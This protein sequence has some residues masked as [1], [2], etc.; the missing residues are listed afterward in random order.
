VKHALAILAAIL[1]AAL[2]LPVTARAQPLAADTGRE[3]SSATRP[4]EVAVAAGVR[5]AIL[6][7]AGLDP[8]A[9][10]S[11][12][13][14]MSSVSAGVT[15]FRAGRASLVG[16]LE[17]NMGSRSDFARG[18]EASVTLHRLGLALETRYQPARRL[19]LSVKLAPAAFA[20]LGSIQAPGIDRPLVARPWT[21][22]LDAT[23]GAG[24]L[25]GT[26]GPSARPSARFWLTAELGYAFAGSA[27]MRYAPASDAADPSRYGSV[28]LPAFKP[29][30]GVGRLGLAVAF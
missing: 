17:W 28:M 13:L 9:P 29:A 14:V 19:Y 1:A 23:G 25:L 24:L 3:P 20:V 27:P 10:G 4:G 7:G 2:A 11:D 26:V 30:G 21:W 18:Q 8:Y 12:L 6:P 16:S 5:A 15:L 22:G